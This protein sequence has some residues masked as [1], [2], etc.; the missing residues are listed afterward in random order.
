[1]DARSTASK[2]CLE[3]WVGARR[4][5]SLV[6][7]GLVRPRARRPVPD[8]PDDRDFA[9][10]DSGIGEADEWGLRRAGHFVQVVEEIR[11]GIEGDDQ[12]QS[13]EGGIVEDADLQ[14][15][16]DF[17]LGRAREQDTRSAELGMRTCGS[18]WLYWHIR[19]KHLSARDYV[20]AFLGT[21]LA[22]SPT[23]GR[24]NE[25]RTASLASWSLGH[26]EGASEQG[27]ESYSI[28]QDLEATT[29]M[30]LVAGL[31]RST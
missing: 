16:L 22:S 9:R 26:F 7:K 10:E 5:E 25:L 17:L 20:R 8:A 1:V 27:L 2:P 21:A 4:S 13:I 19:S 15:G 11:T 29:E 12:V 23:F 6:D 28:E 18:L 3:H 14:A 31:S 30:C 24:S